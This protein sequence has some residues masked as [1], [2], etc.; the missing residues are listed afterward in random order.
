MNTKEVARLIEFSKVVRESTLKRLKKLNF[1]TVNRSPKPGM[2]SFADIAGH[3]IDSDEWMI[4]KIKN[5]NLDPIDGIPGSVIIR[6]EEQLNN[7]FA[8]LEKS[9]IDKC[10]FLGTLEDNVLEEKIYDSR[11]N[12]EVSV[13]WIIVRGN[14]D[15]EI[16]HRGQLAA[17]LSMMD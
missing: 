14:I 11:F 6:S 2:M 4:R 7:L 13:W 5:K 10:E 12:G 1:S 15:H 16:H 17:Y 3:L 9:L 8:R